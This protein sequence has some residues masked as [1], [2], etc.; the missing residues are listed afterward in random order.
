MTTPK[1][2]QPLYRVT[3]FCCF[4]LLPSGA[5]TNAATSIPHLA[6]RGASVRRPAR[7]GRTTLHLQAWRQAR[8][9]V[10]PPFIPMAAM[11]T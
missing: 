3:L 9:R 7:F 6:A 5:Q 1:V 2:L 8:V 4:A 11:C 10:T